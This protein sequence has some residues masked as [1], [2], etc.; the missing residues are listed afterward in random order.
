[1]T[2][3]SMKDTRRRG[4]IKRLDTFRALVAASLAPNSSET[5]LIDAAVNNATGLNGANSRK[6]FRYE[7]ELVVHPKVAPHF[8][9]IVSLADKIWDD[10]KVKIHS[11]HQLVMKLCNTISGG[12]RHSYAFSLPF[13]EQY[14]ASNGNL[15]P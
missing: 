1:M 10:R 3:D 14:Y 6:T 15:P 12:R 9:R 13:L 4:E 11:R 7:C 8:D 2:L 5:L